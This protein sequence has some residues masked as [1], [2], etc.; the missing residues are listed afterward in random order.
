MREVFP[1]DVV[2]G[3]P[4]GMDGSFFATGIQHKRSHS[5]SSPLRVSFEDVCVDLYRMLS[6]AFQLEWWTCFA[7]G[8]QHKSSHSLSSPLFV[9]QL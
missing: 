1:H 2:R 7:R 9:C 8:I 5:S 3:I 4:T 6:D